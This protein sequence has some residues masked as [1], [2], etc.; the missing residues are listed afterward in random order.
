M[1]N[2]LGQYVCQISPDIVVLLDDREIIGLLKR[3]GLDVARPTRISELG[4]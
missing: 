3:K 4:S 2:R 1:K